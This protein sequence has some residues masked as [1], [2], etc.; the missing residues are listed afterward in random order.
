MSLIFLIMAIEILFM[1]PYIK[2]H[3]MIIVIVIIIAIIIKIMMIIVL[4]VLVIIIAI[5]ITIIIIIIII[6]KNLR[7][8]DIPCGNWCRIFSLL[9]VRLKYTQIIT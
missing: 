4:I 8:I 7:R 1:R 9:A 6:I 3:F 2:S 5:I